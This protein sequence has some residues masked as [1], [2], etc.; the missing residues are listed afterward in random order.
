MTGGLS[1]TIKR[2]FAPFDRLLT[3]F[4]EWGDKRFGK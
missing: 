4:G 1:R 2:I 3:R